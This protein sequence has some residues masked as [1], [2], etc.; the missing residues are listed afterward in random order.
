M[1]ELADARDLKSRVPIGACGFES[2]LGYSIPK[3][4]RLMTVSPFLIARSNPTQIGH[5]VSVVFFLCRW[6]ASTFFGTMSPECQIGT[7]QVFDTLEGLMGSIRL[8]PETGN[9]HR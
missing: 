4:L 2:R 5:S 9:F 3:D 7:S 6:I 1:A 8:D